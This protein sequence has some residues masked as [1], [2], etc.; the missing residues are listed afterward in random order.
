M[1]RR[2]RVPN[3]RLEA[4]YQKF[5]LGGGGEWGTEVVGDLLQVRETSA[6][7]LRTVTCRL[8]GTL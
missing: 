5:F 2:I 6:G 3:D 7:V 1:D 8:L 4:K